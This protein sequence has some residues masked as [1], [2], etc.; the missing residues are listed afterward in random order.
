MLRGLSD[1]PVFDVYSY[2]GELLFSTIMQG[3]DP[4]EIQEVLWWNVSEY[5]LAVFSRDPWEIP[6]VWV[7]DLPE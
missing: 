1:Q 3:I 7:Y 6:L 4:N 2:S 5:G